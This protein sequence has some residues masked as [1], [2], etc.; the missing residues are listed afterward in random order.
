MSMNIMLSNVIKT[1]Y[2]VILRLFFPIIN[3]QGHEVK[4]FLHQTHTATQQPTER[5]IFT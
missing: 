4:D 2:I 1:W 3:I 5:N